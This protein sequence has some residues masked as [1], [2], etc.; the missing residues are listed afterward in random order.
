MIY[1]GTDHRGF[2][3]KEELRKYLEGRGYQVTDLGAFSVA[4]TDYPLVAEQVAKQVAE[5]PNNRGILLCATGAGVCVVANKI[6]GIRAAVVWRKDVAR[7][8][9]SDDS[10]NILCLP[11]DY[12][13]PEEAQEITQ[14]FL[15]TSP[16]GEERY[17]RRLKQIEEI[18]QKN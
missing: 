1:I 16:L 4:S 8:I 12:L 7:S 17:K 2:K 9:R 14:I 18:E 13:S 6:K 11:A 3:I 15:D 5:D 10:V